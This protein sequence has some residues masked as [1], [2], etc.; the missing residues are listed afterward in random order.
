M[1]SRRAS[2]Q[3]FVLD[4]IPIR[5][6]PD[7]AKIAVH[8]NEKRGSEAELRELL[9]MA[10][11]LIQPKAAYLA[12]SVGPIS[13]DQVPI[14]GVTFSSRVLRVNLAKARSVFPFIL[15]IGKC[16]ETEAQASGDLLR[17]YYL[18]TLGDL[19]LHKTGEY[20]A[21]RIK[22]EF[23]LRRLVSMN[24]GSLKD[25]PLTQQKVLFVL[26][27][28]TEH[29]L[30]VRLTDQMLMIP[31]KSISGIDFPSTTEFSS[32]KLCRRENCQGR[33]APY[34]PQLGR[35]YELEGEEGLPEGSCEF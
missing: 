16:L 6:D 34:D 26:F 27:G 12:S 31:R 2:D 30:G 14:G 18:E 33:K 8:W 28:D 17:Q 19:A 5:L 13:G 11:S 23:R 24:P 35:T 21:E 1:K 20:L 25:W 9:E 22:K 4:K 10:Q 29:L 15:T 32:C 7:E 3:V